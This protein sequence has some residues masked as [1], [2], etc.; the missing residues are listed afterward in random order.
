MNNI[1]ISYCESGD[2]IGND[3]DVEEIG[4]IRLLKTA[5]KKGAA[6]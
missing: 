3:A 6:K 2:L 1:I 5:K 4:R